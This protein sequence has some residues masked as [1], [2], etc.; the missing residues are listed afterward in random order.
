MCV[1]AECNRPCHVGQEAPRQAEKD[2]LRHPHAASL[3]IY[4]FRNVVGDGYGRGVRLDR[5]VRATTVDLLGR[6]YVCIMY[7]RDIF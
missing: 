4:V 7:A 3:D 5:E 2:R 1:S 6:L